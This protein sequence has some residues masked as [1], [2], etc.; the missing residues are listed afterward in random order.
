VVN[1]GLR[2]EQHPGEHI[3]TD[4]VVLPV[5]AG[6][7]IKQFV[8]PGTVS[9]RM[10]PKFMSARKSLPPGRSLRRDQDDGHILPQV[11]ALHAG[12]FGE[13]NLDA[14]LPRQIENVNCIPRLSVH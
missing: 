7:G 3:S 1:C 10:V 11:H 9:E 5:L 8:N 13:A 6:I 12:Y 2:H 4:F 14:E